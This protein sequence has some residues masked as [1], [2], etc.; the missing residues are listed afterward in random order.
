MLLKLSLQ[1][2]KRLPVFFQGSLCIVHQIALEV[3]D[4]VEVEEAV[5][6]F[7]KDLH[8][9]LPE[10]QE[11]I[12]ACDKNRKLPA[13]SDHTGDFQISWETIQETK[14]LTISVTNKNDL[15]LTHSGNQVDELT[16][17]YKVVSGAEA[18]R[19][20]GQVMKQFDSNNRDLGEWFE[21][22]YQGETAFYTHDRPYRFE[23]RGAVTVEWKLD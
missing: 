1:N 10:C 23:Y 19:V 13:F 2:E 9:E 4:L 20:V 17:A 15:P 18:A 21:H 7:L 14:K 3:E 16:L 6:S 8:S 22:L 11:V 5:S 12:D